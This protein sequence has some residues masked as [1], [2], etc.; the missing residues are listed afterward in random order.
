MTDGVLACGRALQ[1]DLV[2]FKAYAFAGPLAAKVL[3]VPAVHHLLGP[4]LERDVLE[5]ANDAVS[6]LWRSFGCDTPGYAGVYRDL[7]IQ[8]CPP[9]LETLTVPAG[10]VLSLR[11]APLPEP[12]TS[13]PS[14]RRSS[15]RKAPTISRTP[16]CSN[17][18]A[19]QPC[20]A[21]KR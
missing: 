10:E 2:L 13:T 8:I 19:R 6:P 18:R 20:S 9:S 1:P 21:P 16:T 7:T 12:S 15:S 4:M 14:R 17:V 5:L 3:G 11:P